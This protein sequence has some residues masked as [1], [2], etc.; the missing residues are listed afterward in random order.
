MTTI[1]ELIFNDH[2]DVRSFF[3]QYKNASNKE[4]AIKWYNQIA[5]NVAVHSIAEEIVFYPLIRDKLPN[6]NSLVDNN[7][8]E[9]RNLK[10]SLVQLEKL[11]GKSEEFD[12]KFRAFFGDLWNHME[13]EEKDELPL[14]EKYLT[15]EERVS[16]GSKFYNRKMIAPTRPHTSFPDNSPIMETLTGLLAM[17]LDK[18]R[19]LFKSFP[20]KK[21]VESAKKEGKE[22]F[23]DYQQQGTQQQQGQNLGTQQY[24][25]QQGTQ[26]YS[27][28]QPK[29]DLSSKKECQSQKYDQGQSQK[30]E[31]GQSQKCEQNVSNQ[32]W[33]SN[34]NQG[35]QQEK[36]QDQ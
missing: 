1:E 6:G 28:V 14:L 29:E 21:D 34:Q 27:Y 10:E 8:E 22:D 15:K 18:F 19:D 31:Q 3:E 9:H 4:E 24:S 33:S 35:L 20:D 7:L 36:R 11:D 13:R 25:Q 23:Q 30:C 5:H 32:Q 26:Q 2:N 17:P 16:L 12:I